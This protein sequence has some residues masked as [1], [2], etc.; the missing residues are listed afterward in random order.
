RI[1]VCLPYADVRHMDMLNI[2]MLLSFSRKIRKKVKPDL[3]EITQ[4][5]T[6]IHSPIL[7]VC[8]LYRLIHLI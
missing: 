7:P 1:C 3:N 4:N 2:C 5:L 6:E 8:Y